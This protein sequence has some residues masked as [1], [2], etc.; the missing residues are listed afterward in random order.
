MRSFLVT[1]AVRDYSAAHSS[2]QPDA[3]VRDLQ[4]RTRA[5]GGP[6]GMQIGDDQGRS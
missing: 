5:L 1:D 2:W 6:A 4:E 3:V